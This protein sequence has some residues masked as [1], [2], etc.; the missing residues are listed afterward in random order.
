MDASARPRLTMRKNWTAP[1][2]TEKG[3]VVGFG[4]LDRGESSPTKIINHHRLMTTF[5]GS[6]VAQ[7][8]S[9]PMTPGGDRKIQSSNRLDTPSVP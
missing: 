7:P 1:C 3:A 4:E 9:S 8:V 6:A 2:I 5:F